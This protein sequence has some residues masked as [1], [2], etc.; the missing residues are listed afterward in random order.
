MRIL[1]DENI[2][3][4]TVEYLQEMGHDVKD[5]RGT[6]LE[7]VADEHV[8]DLAQKEGRLLITTDKGFLQHRHDEHKGTLVVRLKQPNR[9]KIHTRVL[10]AISEVV[11]TDWEGTMIV[12]RDSVQSISKSLKHD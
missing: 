8:W 1:V 11:E 12:M 7:G 2:P 4:M 10:K 6:K 9:L 5:I 3:K